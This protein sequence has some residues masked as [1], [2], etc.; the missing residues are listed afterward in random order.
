MFKPK[1]INDPVYG[2]ISID[3][4]LIFDIIEHPL[5]Q[6]QRRIKQL[7]LSYMVYPG[8]MHTRYQHVVGATYLMQQAID[9]LAAKGL[10]LNHDDRDAAMVAILLHDLG[11]GPFSHTLENS[12]FT[13][14]S[15]EQISEEFMKIIDRDY[16]GDLQGGIQVFN[17]THELKILHKLVSSQLDM[18]RLDY[19]SRDSFFTGVNEGVISSDRIIK[20]LNF[21]GDEPVIEYKGIYSIE[22]FLIARRLM[23]WQ[24]YLHKTVVVAEEMLKKIISRAKKLVQSGID[25][26]A[27]PQLKFFLSHDITY[28]K[29]H[30]KFAGITPLQYFADLDDS[31]IISAIKVWRYCDDYVLSNMCKRLIDRRLFKIEISNDEI[32]ESRIQEIKD[33]ILAKGIVPEEHIDDFVISGALYNRAYSRHKD[34]K[35]K[36]LMKDGHVKDIN[37]TSDI[38]IVSALSKTV[39]KYFV[40]YAR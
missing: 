34:E 13:D 20:M 40:C 11:H 2:I 38:S 27:P 26:Y 24:V 6:R 14:I 7:G 25:L 9:E 8:A 29:L 3:N 36:I 28:D 5:L 4:K 17:N 35:I 37:A 33:G 22:K 32:P 31:D 23:Y 15:H 16:N 18:D 39:T 30:D 19:L 12:F 1:V 10:R 21:H